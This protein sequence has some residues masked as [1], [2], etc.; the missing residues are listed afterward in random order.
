MGKSKKNTKSKGTQYSSNNSAKDTAK[1]T[2]GV[3]NIIP[4]EQERRD[5]P[6][7]E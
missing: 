7:G 4:D 6:G 3:K 5:G 2:S 1:N